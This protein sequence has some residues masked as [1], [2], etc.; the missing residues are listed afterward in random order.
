MTSSY[1]A[2]GVLMSRCRKCDHDLYVVKSGKNVGHVR[3][4][5]RACKYATKN[6]VMG[7][8]V[9]SGEDA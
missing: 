8:D 9:N 7:Q 3:C 6:Y 5:N 1:R 2:N 4:T